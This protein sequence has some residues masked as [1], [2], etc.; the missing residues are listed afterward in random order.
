[1]SHPSG[2]T[3]AANEIDANIAISNDGRFV[4]YAAGDLSQNFRL[5]ATYV[6]PLD[7]LSP[8]L[9]AAAGRA[10]FFSPDGQWVGWLSRGEFQRAAVTGGAPLTLGSGSASGGG[11]SR[12]DLRGV[13]WGP[14]QTIVFANGDFVPGLMRIAVG[15]GELEVLTTPDRAAGESDH[16]FPRFLPGGR[17]VLLLSRRLRSRARKSLFSISKPAN[18]AR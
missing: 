10:P 7:A 8:T 11:G 18:T 1:M 6:R 15:G 12:G 17:H 13:D 14:D 9:I 4:A 16:W 3:V 2:E 5:S